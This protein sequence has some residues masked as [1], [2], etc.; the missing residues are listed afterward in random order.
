M[1]YPPGYGD[2][3]P[4]SNDPRLSPE[5]ETPDYYIYNFDFTR[6]S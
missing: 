4:G 2:A 5:Q 3:G 6:G 1:P